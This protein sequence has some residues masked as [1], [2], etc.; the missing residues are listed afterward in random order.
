MTTYNLL[1]AEQAKPI[2]MWTQ[3][4]P[5]D[6][7][8]KAQLIK[9][10]QLPFIFQHIAVMPDVH[11]G[12][13]STI[14][15]VIP[16]LG[17]VIPAA[18]GVDI[19]CGMMAVQTSL[20][21]ADLPDNLLVLRQEIEKAVPH[22]LTPRHRGRDRVAGRIRPQWLISTGSSCCRDLSSLPPNIR[23]FSI[24]ITIAIWARSVPVI[25]LLKSVWMKS[26]GCG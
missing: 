3:G 6:E 22:G 25:T 14:G 26:S 24:P 15:S 7:K 18:V 23:D 8:A 12:K 20:M 19:G 16:T 4:V 9:T 5:V 1:Q 11:V 2:K 21:A 17:A 13:G 10:A